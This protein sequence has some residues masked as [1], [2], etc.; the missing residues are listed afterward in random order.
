MADAEEEPSA[1]RSRLEV[2]NKQAEIGE[3]DNLVTS[4]SKLVESVESVVQEGERDCKDADSISDYI[5]LEN[6]RGIK[7]MFKPMPVYA[8][9]MLEHD[10]KTWKDFEGIVKR[11]YKDDGVQE[12]IEELLSA[13]DSYEHFVKEREE[14]L[15]VT[16]K[17]NSFNETEILAIGQTI[18]KEIALLEAQSGNSKPLTSYCEKAKFTLFILMR[19]YGWSP[20]NRHIR[21]A[22]AQQEELDSLGCQ[23][24][25]VA[26]NGV[27]ESGLEFIKSTN[28][29][30]PLL[31]D[32]TREFTGG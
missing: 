16:E 24:I 30:F 25:V 6:P 4:L 3:K 14:E 8:Q 29:T 28:L 18:P 5:K 12:L 19:H 22:V 11:H 7:L 32:G 17:E 13:E 2:G 23:V 31:L 10:V 15:A 27:R 21:A 20:W 9:C 26:S 1:K